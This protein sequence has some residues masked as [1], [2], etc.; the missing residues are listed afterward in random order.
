MDE[1]GRPRMVDVAAKPETTRIAI[2]E[3]SI[4]MSAEAL[5]LI[6]GNSSPKGDV[7]STAE[8]AGTMG[9][10]RTAELIPL[11]HPVGLDHISVHAVAEPD[12]PGV[13]VTAQAKAIGRTGVE[14][15]A[16]TAAA[17]AL[18]TVYDM[19]KSVGH[20]LE[21]GNVHLLQKTGGRSGD[22]HRPHRSSTGLREG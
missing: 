11:C 7:L 21:I 16:L 19:V 4:R 9:A 12:L 3:G 6:V 15:E 10:K 2:A 22:W 8:L 14:M 5:A 18:L 20:D 1:Q 13:R 17:V